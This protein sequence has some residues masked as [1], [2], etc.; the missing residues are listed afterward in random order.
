MFN[1]G[2]LNLVYEIQ[3]SGGGKQNIYY[4]S[5]IEMPKQ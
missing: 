4:L 1:T 2:S 5:N 3:K